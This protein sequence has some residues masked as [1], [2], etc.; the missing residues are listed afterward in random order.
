MVIF[1][2]VKPALYE[3]TVIFFCLLR[4]EIVFLEFLSLLLFELACP[5]CEDLDLLSTF[6]LMKVIVTHWFPQETHVKFKGA[7]LTFN[8]YP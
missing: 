3:S 1:M 5:I 7:E 6:K 8:L 2:I 4:Q